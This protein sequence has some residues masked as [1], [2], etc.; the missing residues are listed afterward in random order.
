MNIVRITSG[1]GNQLFQ[2]AFYK[3]LK[4]KQPDTKMDISEFKYRKHH[5][6]FE[7]EKIFQITPDYASKE[8]CNYLADVSK[9]WVSEFRRKYLHLHLPSHGKL[10]KEDVIGTS[11]HTELL[12]LQNTYFWGYWQTEKYFSDI[13]ELL[14]SE[15]VFTKLSDTKNLQTAELI[16][17]HESVSIHIRR[18]D[19][20][21]K[22]RFEFCGSVCS[23]DYYKQA[24][25]LILDRVDNPYFFIF[26]DDLEWVKSNISLPN[27]YFI[28]NNRGVDSY[29]DMQLMSLCKHNIIANSSFSWWGAWLGQHEEKIAIAPSIWFRNDPMP[30]IVPDSWIRIPVE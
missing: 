13:A 27:A 15:L 28:D 4:T 11:F 29:K 8:E 12:S 1:L 22:R 14:H 7:L 20:V 10:I 2:Y 25:D 30:D 23:T 6:G 21:K 17:N 26:S 9:D 19:Y 24:T 18:G 5:Y 16:K 3:A